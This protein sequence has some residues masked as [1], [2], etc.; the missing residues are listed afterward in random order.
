MAKIFFVPVASSD[1][2]GMGEYGA[3]KNKKWSDHVQATKGETFTTVWY[4]GKEQKVLHDMADGQIYIRGHGMPGESTIEIGRGGQRLA[5]AEV[6]KRL[7]KSGL[8]KSFRGKIKCYNCHSAEGAPGVAGGKDAF[9][10]LFTNL[11][12]SLGYTE[13]RYYGYYG[14]LD[15]FHKDG[16]AG[17]H[18]YSREMQTEMRDGIAYGKQVELGRASDKRYEI[19]PSPGV[20]KSLFQK[21]KDLF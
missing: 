16:S 1:A 12:Y 4:T 8:K 2:F 7:K 6:A 21:I 10:V 3:D 9:A 14:Q 18:K 13:C 19:V 20:S 15:S 5:A 11:M 17:K